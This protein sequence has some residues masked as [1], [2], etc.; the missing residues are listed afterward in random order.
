MTRRRWSVSFGEVAAET[1]QPDAAEDTAPKKPKPPSDEADPYADPKW[2]VDVMDGV[3]SQLQRTAALLGAA[4]VAVIGGLGYAQLHN[5]FPIP[6]NVSVASKV[7]LPCFVVAA[8]GGASWLAAIFLSAQRRILIGPDW[9]DDLNERDKKVAKRVRGAFARHEQADNL[10]DVHLRTL[11]LA[12]VARA[13]TARDAKR[14]NAAKAEADRVRT[15]VDFALIRTAAAILEDR[16]RRAFK[17]LP[18]LF[19]L[20]LASAGIV[21]MFAV[22]DSY[23]GRRDSF[24]S[25]EKC[26]KAEANGVADACAAFESS[27]QTAERHAAEAAAKEAAAK[28]AKDAMERLT[29]TQQALVR[30]A[31]DCETAVDALPASQRPS[32][33]A[34]VRAVARC[35]SA[36]P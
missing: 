14:A 10:M 5:I 22:A 32:G 2:L 19:A 18:T 28:K 21:G 30:R 31:A 13:L 24:E 8:I 25:R 23:K 3:R 29:P 6:R 7:A 16:S 17:G 36:L 34:R 27:E 26:A 20:I 33:Q 4:A 11:R 9:D 15:L 35:V 1:R 12:A